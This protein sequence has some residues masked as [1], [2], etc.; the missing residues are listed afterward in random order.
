MGLVSVQD[1]FAT[2]AEQFGQPAAP[3][4]TEVLQ[5][6]VC[7]IGL[8]ETGESQLLFV[9]EFHPL[10]ILMQGLIVSHYT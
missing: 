9:L 8:K 4:H 6:P 7:C 5:E 3:F 2:L 1:H 10:R